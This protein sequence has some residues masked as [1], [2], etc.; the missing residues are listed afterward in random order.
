MAVYAA[1]ISKEI[2]DHFHPDTHTCDVM[3]FVATVLL[4]TV[5]FSV[6]TLL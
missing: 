2:Y 1:A 5:V 4:P 6:V 3:D